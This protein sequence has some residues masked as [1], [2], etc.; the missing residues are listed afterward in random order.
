MLKTS[1]IILALLALALPVIAAPTGDPIDSNDSIDIPGCN[2]AERYPDCV[3]C[4]TTC[5]YAMIAQTWADGDWDNDG[6]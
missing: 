1:L 6:W 5:I 4:W 2:D 3:P